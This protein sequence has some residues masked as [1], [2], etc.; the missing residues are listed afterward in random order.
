MIPFFLKV[1]TDEDLDVVCLDMLQAGMETVGNTI[2]FMFLYMVRQENV[3][4]KVIAEIDAVIG[5]RTPTLEDRRRYDCKSVL[6]I[7]LGKYNLY[8]CSE[9]VN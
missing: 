8:Y 7:N 9:I 6:E 4:N 2:A 3:Q 5:K 1:G